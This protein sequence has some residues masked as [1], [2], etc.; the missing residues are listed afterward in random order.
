MDDYTASNTLST[1]PQ[2]IPQPAS[3]PNTING[4]DDAIE[5]RGS[6]GGGRG[7]GSLKNMVITRPEFTPN[8]I[9]MD[10]EIFTIS[11]HITPSSSLTVPY[12]FPHQPADIHSI[13]TES[14]D[15]TSF[16][17]SHIEDN[18]DE[19]ISPRENQKSHTYSNSYSDLTMISGTPLSIPPSPLKPDFMPSSPPIPSTPLRTSQQIYPG[20]STTPMRSFLPPQHT[21][22]PFPFST[23]YFNPLAMPPTPTSDSLPSIPSLSKLILAGSPS[24]HLASSNSNRSTLTQS[25]PNPRLLYH[26]PFTPSP[27]Y[28]SSLPFTIQTEEPPLQHT[29]TSPLPP[30]QLESSNTEEHPLEPANIEEHTLEPANI[31]EH[32]LE[33]SNIEKHPLNIGEH[34]QKIQSHNSSAKF[35]MSSLRRS[36]IRFDFLF[37]FFFRFSPPPPLLKL[38]V[39]R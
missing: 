9:D 32:P 34:Q 13:T 36:G 12:Q 2:D 10:F 19:Y 29:P 33:S 31:E 35:P 18:N 17:S 27:L 39:N 21:P 30:H 7:L 14:E 24:V 22:S 38:K 4:E 28:Q 5:Q 8:N 23:S 16:P 25:S 26:M 15:I 3:Q 6:F 20:L 1:Q 11:D 37:F